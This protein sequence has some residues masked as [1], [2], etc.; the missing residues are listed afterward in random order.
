MSRSR[1]HRRL[2]AWLA[3]A[4]LGLLLV[5]PVLSRALAANA[6]PDLGAWC[7]GHAS[8]PHG[9]PSMPDHGTA[10]GACGYCALLSHSPLIASS[11]VMYLAAFAPVPVQANAPQFV[12]P[13]LRTLP[14]HLRGPP[15]A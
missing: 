8:H 12:A 9:V 6:E 3:F 1:I 15:F 7:T 5:A 10:D 14:V 11:F 4:A 2:T 13:Y